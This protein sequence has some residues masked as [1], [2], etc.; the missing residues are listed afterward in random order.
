MPPMPSSAKTAALDLKSPAQIVV[1]QIGSAPSFET[2]AGER[3]PES[4]TA[5]LTAAL[6][7]APSKPTVPSTLPRRFSLSKA[8]L[9]VPTSPGQNFLT[10]YLLRGIHGSL[11]LLR[12][13][14]SSL[15]PGLLFKL[16]FLILSEQKPPDW[17]CTTS[18]AKR[19]SYQFPNLTVPSIP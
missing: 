17:S 10:G 11:K 15:I 12:E 2:N 7:S 16:R 6:S 13:G 9:R 18:C 3:R 14:T 5:T 19:E 8:S 4:G 1:V